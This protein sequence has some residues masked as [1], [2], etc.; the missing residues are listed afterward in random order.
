LDHL[1]PY[2]LILIGIEEVQKF[3]GDKDSR[4]QGGSS[5]RFECL[6][7][8]FEDGRNFVLGMTFPFYDDF[9]VNGG[10]GLDH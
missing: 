3:V 8:G 10:D 7:G 4:G 9:T 1:A 2:Q 6:L 5:M